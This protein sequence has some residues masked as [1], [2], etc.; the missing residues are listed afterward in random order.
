MLWDIFCR[1]IDNHGDLGVT[2][3]LARDL[4]ARGHQ[5]RLWVDDASALAWMAPDRHDQHEGVAV[6]PWPAGDVDAVPGDVVIEAFGCEVPPAFVARMAARRPA[7]R[8]VNLEY[9]SAED[10]VERSHGLASPQFHGPGA[11]LVK[12]FFYPGFT[13]RTGGLLREPDLL[14]RRA[15]FDGAA[16]LA[17]HGW[18]P[19]PGER[20]VSL[21]AYANPGLPA[22]LD[23][24]A[25]EPTL[26]R[27][28]A[29][30][31]GQPSGPALHRPA[32]PAPGR[33]RPAAL[34]LRPQLR[35]R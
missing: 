13:A 31:S 29:G 11:G 16:W 21:F 17:A 9:L 35:A 4:A 23:A 28:W 5:A 25:Q 20:V 1:V 3:R 30:A 15:A 27:P 24:L 8:W 22:L 10:Y 19:Q 12:H 2:W 6:L 33:L 32:L 26:H 7:P 34:G 18:A 14:A